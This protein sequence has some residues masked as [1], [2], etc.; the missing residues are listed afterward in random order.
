M[1]GQYGTGALERRHAAND[2]RG[3]WKEYI[4]HPTPLALD[5]QSQ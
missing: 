4:P 5:A 1:L 2:K 3:Q